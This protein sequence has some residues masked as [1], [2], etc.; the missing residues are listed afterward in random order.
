M[1]EKTFLV[2]EKMIQRISWKFNISG[3]D[4][5]DILQEARI[6]AIEIIEKKGI[7]SDNIDEYMGLIN[8]AVRGALSNLRKANQAQKRSALNNA[9]SLDAVISD[10]SDVSLLDFIPAK[11]EMTETVLRETLEKVKNIAIKTKDKRAIR[12]VIH[13]LVELLNISVDNISKEI[14]YYS[15][16]ENGLGYFLWIFFNNSPYRALSMAYPQITVE[17]MK[18]APNG[19]WSGRI[20]KSRGVRK[21][22]KLLEESGYEK[23]LFPSIVCESFIENNG[24]S[25]PY[26]AH[27]NSSPFHFLD[28]AYPRQFKPWEMN[29]TPSEFMNTKMAKKAVRWVVEKRLGILLSEMHPHDVWREKVALRVTKEKLCEHG[30]RG[31]VKHFGDNSETL[32]RLV[33]PGK[34]QEWDFQRKGE[35]QGEAGRKLAAKATRWVIEDYSGLHPQSPKIDWRFFVENGLYGM[36]SAKSLGFNSSPKAAL[37]NAYP[38]MRFD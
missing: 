22:R 8:V 34:F 35:W 16:K 26:Q 15:F 18:K 5:E 37:Q 11:E 19:Y 4:Y 23:E 28:A 33:Y 30:L 13:C 32:M 24:L 25:R 27:F 6:A 9:I 10:E 31:F 7:D 1:D 29:W 20:G 2:I 3:Y 21:L 12:G 17:S 14:N 36:I 38:D